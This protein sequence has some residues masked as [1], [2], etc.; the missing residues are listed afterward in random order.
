MLNLVLDLD[1][2]I[3]NTMIADETNIKQ[4][5]SQELCIGS[6]IINEN[7]EN[8]KNDKNISYYLVVFVRPNLY[9]FLKFLNKNF[10]L[11]IYTHAHIDYA[12]N[13]INLI[14]ENIIDINVKILQTRILKN[15]IIQLKSLSTLKL[16]K[17]DTLIIDDRIDVWE[18]EYHNNIIQ[19]EPYYAPHY[20]IDYK[21]EN[22]LIYNK[23]NWKYNFDNSL[24]S[25]IV[26]L[27]S[28]NIYY[29]KYGISE[30]IQKL[31]IKN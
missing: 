18:K 25:L 20:L 17:E 7:D 9:N 2:T 27:K 24:L 4:I 19:I 31:F 8:D 22:K 15:D 21:A 23:F 3:I 11:Y 30:I 5:E 28:V 14:C 16:S 1:E 13:V 26:M 29:N 10:N 12:L 6:F